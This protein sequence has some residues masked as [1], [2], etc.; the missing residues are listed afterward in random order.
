MIFCQC[1]DKRIFPAAYACLSNKN[2]VSYEKLLLTIKS[3][4]AE[5]MILESFRIDFE[6]GMKTAVKMFF[7]EY[8]F[9]HSKKA[10]WT[11]FIFQIRCEL[12]TL[13]KYDIR[14]IAYLPVSEVFI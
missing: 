9:F 10:I 2:T 13:I 6:N 11:N 7:Q 5:P 4:M 14:I 8:K 1:Q 3:A 12:P